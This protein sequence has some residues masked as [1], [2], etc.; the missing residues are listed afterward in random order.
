MIIQEGYLENVL[1]LDTESNPHTKQPECVQWLLGGSSGIIEDFSVENYNLLTSLWNKSDCVCMYNAPY[2][3]GV[4]SIT[5]PENNYVWKVDKNEENEDDTPSAMWNMRLFGNMYGVR[6][7]G[8]H[9]NLIKPMRQDDG[10]VS[11]ASKRKREDSKPVIDILKLWSILIDD[12]SKHG[13]LPKQLRGLGLK[14]VLARELKWETI[15][16]SEENSKTEEYRMQDV[17]GLKAVADLF[18]KKIDEGIPDLKHFNFEMWAYIKTPATFTKLAYE[19]VYDMEDI[20]EMYDYQIK[21]HGIKGVLEEAFHGGLTVSFHRGVTNKSGWVDICGAYNKAMEYMNVDRFMRF[22]VIKHMGVEGDVDKYNYLLKIKTNFAMVTINKSLKL[23]KLETPTTQWMWAFDVRTCKNL[24]KDFQYTVIESREFI[25]L[26]D[27]EET[28]TAQWGREKDIEKVTN[29]KTTFYDF[30][31]FRSNTGYGIKAQRKPFTTKHTNMVIAGMITSMVHYILSEI[32]D[33]LEINNLICNYTD[34][35]SWNFK[36]PDCFGKYSMAA[37]VE[38]VNNR[39]Y[40]FE[41]DSEGFNKTTEILSLKRYMSTGGTD[42]DKVRL[43]GKGRYE[44]TEN[45]VKGYIKNRTVEDERLFIYQIGANTQRGINQIVKLFNFVEE[46]KHPFMFVTHIESDNK[47]KIDFFQNWFQHIDTK[48][49][50]KTSGEFRREFHTFKNMTR[51]CM[52]FNSYTDE[53]DYTES[54]EKRKWDKELKED[55]S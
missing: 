4:L 26:M 15:P 50:F 11:I 13:K 8:T 16:Y 41:I 33:E 42:K 10:K 27:V 29:G 43:H 37:L 6:K 23:F 17:L 55:F 32:K 40:P 39:I 24:H 48:T 19:E 45:E 36:H 9:R 22:D 2:D 35:D 30:C 54:I 38:T 34:T 1:F 12:G 21:K 14:R 46:F 53:E 47:T 44:I 25:P 3:F 7:L 51:A 5:F 31:K 18:F 52:F 20:S 28:L 49:T